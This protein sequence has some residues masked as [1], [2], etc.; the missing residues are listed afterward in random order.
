MLKYTSGSSRK[1]EWIMYQAYDLGQG[2]EEEFC[3]PLGQARQPP[4][5]SSAIR[6]YYHTKVETLVYI[7]TSGF[8]FW[9]IIFESSIYFICFD[10]SDS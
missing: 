10:G 5:A 8:S 4:D 1:E 6:Q 7:C 3:Q 9:K 2:S